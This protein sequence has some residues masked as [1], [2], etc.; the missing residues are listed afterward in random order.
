MFMHFSSGAAFHVVA[1]RN[2]PSIPPEP[3]PLAC[4]APQG[5][6]R[7]L[8]RV[9]HPSGE[10]ERAV[11]LQ[12][13]L[14]LAKQVARGASALQSLRQVTVTRMGRDPRAGLGRAEHDQGDRQR[15]HPAR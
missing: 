7:R 5:E 1:T 4:R 13:M 15:L 2:A 11:V 9:R 8:R 6:R 12:H 10:P 3:P 14:A